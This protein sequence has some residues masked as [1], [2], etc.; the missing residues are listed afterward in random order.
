MRLALVEALFACAALSAFPGCKASVE[1]NV[2]TGKSDEEVADFDKPLDLS[3]V[4]RAPT[5]AV[6]PD[7]ALLGARQDLAFNGATTAKCKCLA[8]AVGSPSDAAFQWASTRP[9]VDG[10][11]SVVLAFTSSG[12]TCDA[13]PSANGASYW[14]Y[15]VVGQDV[16]VVVES[17][18]PG[19]PIAQGAI[20]PRPAAGGQIYVRPVDS[21]VPYGRPLSGT[22]PR[23]QVAT[24]AQ[25]PVAAAAAP[26]PTTAPA[27][28]SGWH[29]IKTEQSDP[30]STRFDQP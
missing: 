21:T 11:T 27:A 10:N 30:S 18:K 8:V 1:G 24:L 29:S 7:A 2:N 14:G 6:P 15:E 17:A 3:G 26:A 5:T 16:V 23:C 22:G 28:S 25:A 12:V 9:V 19:R 4:N 13:A 20:I